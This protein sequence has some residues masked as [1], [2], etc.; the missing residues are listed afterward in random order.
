MK[1]SEMCCQQNPLSFRKAH[2]TGQV[3]K[4]FF[5][6]ISILSLMKH[7]LLHQD[8]L[9]TKYKKGSAASTFVISPKLKQGPPKSRNVARE[10]NYKLHG[11][12]E[13]SADKT[14]NIWAYSE[15]V[16]TLLVD[17]APKY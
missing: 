1:T 13:C 6:P 2:V 10:S 4:H 15:N 5:H 16:Y 11:G 9:K 12:T 17:C 8:F 7:H 3:G 14:L